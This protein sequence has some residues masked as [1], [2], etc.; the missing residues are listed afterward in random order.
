[1]I[2]TFTS[3]PCPRQEFTSLDCISCISRTPA[4]SLAA[5][6]TEHARLLRISL[7]VEREIDEEYQR[8]Q[9][10]ADDFF[11][12][13]S[14]DSDGNWN[15][16]RLDEIDRFYRPEVGGTPAM[17]FSIPIYDGLDGRTRHLT[18]DVPAGWLH[19]PTLADVAV[20]GQHMHEDGSHGS[21]VLRAM[22]RSTIL[23]HSD[24]AALA[25]ADP[26]GELAAEASLR[27]FEQAA[28]QAAPSD[29]F[30][31][32]VNGAAF[33]APASPMSVASTITADY[34]PLG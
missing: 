11:D 32:P 14:V 1:M 17:S 4:H 18:L 19:N 24:E 6:R 34:D 7:E 20:E 10:D 12:R 27:R 26:T 13:W 25:H 22:L 2:Y 31:R 15:D 5:E 33:E 23:Q 29:N 16:R 8:R 9:D 21:D 3:R 28:L 30:A